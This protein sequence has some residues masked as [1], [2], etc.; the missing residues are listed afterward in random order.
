MK[1]SIYCY[2]ALVEPYQRPHHL[3]ISHFSPLLLIITF[4]LPF[5]L[6]TTLNFNVT[7]HL[8]LLLPFYFNSS[9]FHSITINMTFSI[10]FYTYFLTWKRLLLSLFLTHVL[11]LCEFFIFCISTLDWCI[12]VF[13]RILIWVAIWF[14]VFK[15]LSF[16][17]FL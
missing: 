7:F 5:H 16:F 2:Y 4:L 10:P 9:Y 17:S 12:Y 8:S 3:P 1:R 15:L 14:C 13:F 6:S 11:F